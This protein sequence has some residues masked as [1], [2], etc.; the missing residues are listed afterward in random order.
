MKPETVKTRKNREEH[1]DH[2]PQMTSNNPEVPLLR[3]PL[4]DAWARI[5]PHGH[6]RARRRMDAHDGKMTRSSR[7]GLQSMCLAKSN[8][9]EATL[10]EKVDQIDVDNLSAIS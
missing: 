2:A 1:D 4:K 7:S 6:G 3:V 10:N 5:E 8:S 9:I